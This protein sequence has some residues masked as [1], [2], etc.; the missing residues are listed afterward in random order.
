MA[1]IVVGDV[2]REAVA[3]KIRS[4]FSSLT[5]PSPRRPRPAFD[6]PEQPG[7]RYAIVDRQGDTDDRGGD[8]RSSA[9]AQP[10]FGGRLS[11]SSS[12]DQ[13]FGDMLDARLDE[14]SQR[15]NAPFLRAA[16]DRTCS[17]CRAPRTKR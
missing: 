5:S 7:T 1:V 8:Q 13:L 10:G 6:V 9:G 15:E 12:L 17:R 16:A 11:R 4:R 2:D 14:L 3:T